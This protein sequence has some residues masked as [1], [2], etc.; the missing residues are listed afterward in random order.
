MLFL[1]LYGDN[2]YDICSVIVKRIR[3]EENTFYVRMNICRVDAEHE[4]NIGAN[5]WKRLSTKHT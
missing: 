3:G 1:A 4:F 2:I 5:L